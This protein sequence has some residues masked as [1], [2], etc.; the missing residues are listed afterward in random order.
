MEGIFTEAAWLIVTC[1]IAVIGYF[2]KKTVTEIHDCERDVQTLREEC[3]KKEEL[4]EIHKDLK[5]VQI[6][7]IHKNDFFKEMA[8]IDNKLER[9]TDIMMDW[10]VN[11]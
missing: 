3:V 7:Y 5:D 10:R 8:K 11:K 1:A 4:Q 6:N 9:I 2:L